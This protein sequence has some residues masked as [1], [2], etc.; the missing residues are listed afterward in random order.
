MR[1]SLTA[2]FSLHTPEVTEGI[3]ESCLSEC[4]T[5]RQANNVY[6]WT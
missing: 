1:D 3:R 2:I 6:K 5:L 4:G